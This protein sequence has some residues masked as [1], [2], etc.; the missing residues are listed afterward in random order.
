MI[1]ETVIAGMLFERFFVLSVSYGT[2]MKFETVCAAFIADRTKT[3]Q[4]SSGMFSDVVHTTVFKQLCTLFDASC[5]TCVTRKSRNFVRDK[6]DLFSAV[7]CNLILLRKDNKRVLF[8]RFSL[9]GFSWVIDQISCVFLWC[10]ICKFNFQ[11][12]VKTQNWCFSQIIFP[13][14]LIYCCNL[15]TVGI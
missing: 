10:G 13:V 15:F 12:V 3:I 1:F 6:L 4:Q 5:T 7:N 14:H 2:G 11:L 9:R 8:I